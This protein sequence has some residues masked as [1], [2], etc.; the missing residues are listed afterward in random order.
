MF[1]PLPCLVL[2]FKIMEEKMKNRVRTCCMLRMSAPFSVLCQYHCS[3]RSLG[4]PYTFHPLANELLGLTFGCGFS[5]LPFL[6][7]LFLT[8]KCLYFIAFSSVSFHCLS[9]GANPHSCGIGGV[10]IEALC[11]VHGTLWSFSPFFKH[12]C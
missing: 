11:A 4:C 10:L 9:H 6:C 1:T 12:T 5:P 3:F 8:L 7:S 2:T